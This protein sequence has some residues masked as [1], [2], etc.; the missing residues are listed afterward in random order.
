MMESTTTPPAGYLNALR[1]LGDG[2]LASVQDRMQLFAVELQEEK[3]RTD[4]DLHLDQFG[5]FHRHDGGDLCEPY[6]RLPFLG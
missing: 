3:F 1:S 4:P 2:V 5:G 6:A